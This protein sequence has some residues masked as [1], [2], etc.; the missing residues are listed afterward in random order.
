MVEFKQKQTKAD[1]ILEKADKLLAIIGED[2]KG[3]ALI[4][5]VIRLE[6]KLSLLLEG[7]EDELQ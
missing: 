1:M 3:E 7:K 2:S 5:R 6:T 4:S